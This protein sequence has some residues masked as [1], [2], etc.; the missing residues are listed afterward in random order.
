ML[1][2]RARTALGLFGSVDSTL[3]RAPRSAGRPPANYRNKLGFT[4]K[5]QREALGLEGLLEGACG[6]FG[7][8]AA[9]AEFLGRRC[10]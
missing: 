6:N 2:C 10:A 4:T 9:N 1:M 5:G 7:S 8:L 3:Q